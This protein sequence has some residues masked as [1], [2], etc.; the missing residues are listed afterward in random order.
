MGVAAAINDLTPSQE[1]MQFIIPLV[2]SKIS[3]F[4]PDEQEVYAKP[5]ANYICSLKKELASMLDSFDESLCE[6]LSCHIYEYV[7]LYLYQLS[8]EECLKMV[9]CLEL[10]TSKYLT[11]R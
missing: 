1:F 7:C 10:E 3:I 2:G 9:F 11:V 8:F 4:E 5:V 6:M